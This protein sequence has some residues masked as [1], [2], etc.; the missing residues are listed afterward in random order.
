M[1]LGFG[2]LREES[3]THGIPPFL[4]EIVLTDGFFKE[5]ATDLVF[6]INLFNH[7]L[8][9]YCSHLRFP[10]NSLL[11]SCLIKTDFDSM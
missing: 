5:M 2:L 3:H 6:A 1:I 7:R 10:S 8:L 4:R 11:P 9:F